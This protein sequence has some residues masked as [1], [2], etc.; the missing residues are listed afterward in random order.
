M[1]RPRKETFVVKADQ[2]IETDILKAL[3][4][5]IQYGIKIKVTDLHWFLSKGKL[6]VSGSLSVPIEAVIEGADFLLAQEMYVR[7]A[8]RKDK[9]GNY[10]IGN[11]I[12]KSGNDIS[13]AN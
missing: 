4:K 10:A 12:D 13:H 7:A 11:I 9:N 2:L 1:A 6:S 8:N 5:Y 3:D